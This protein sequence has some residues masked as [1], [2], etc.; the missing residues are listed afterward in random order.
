MGNGNWTWYLWTECAHH[1][2][3]SK[4]E[5]AASYVPSNMAVLLPVRS[6]CT[7]SHILPWMCSSHDDLWPQV[8]CVS[9]HSIPLAL[10]QYYTETTNM[11]ILSTS[12]P[13][14]KTQVGNMGC[15]TLHCSPNLSQSQSWG[16]N[17]HFLSVDSH[18]QLH[19]SYKYISQHKTCSVD[20][21]T[22]TICQWTQF[23]M[24]MYSIQ[25]LHNM[26]P[27]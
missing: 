21:A 15:L 11:H 25:M 26:L 24:G 16:H 17:F 20:I 3:H 6:L 12:P 10:L 7:H 2:M 18:P 27:I 5:A 23:S 9:T 14:R 1:P 13:L 8:H 19:H 4:S 22:K